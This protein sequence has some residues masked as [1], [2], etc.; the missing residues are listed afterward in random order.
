MKTPTTPL[1][2]VAPELWQAAE[3]SL[4]EGETLSAFVEA[5]LRAQIEQRRLQGESVARGPAARDQA[6]RASRHIGADA[7]IARLQ[8][9]LDKARK[10]TRA[11]AASDDKDQT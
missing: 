7:M 4:H 11:S 2:R 10:S 3:E 6:R 8:S 1:F 9:Q 5:A